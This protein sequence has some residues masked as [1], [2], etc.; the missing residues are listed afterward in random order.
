MLPNDVI[1][2]EQPGPELNAKTQQSLTASD[3]RKVI[4]W[5]FNG[6]NTDGS[7]TMAVSNLLL[8]PLKINLLA[9]D[10]G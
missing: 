4:Q 3:T 9:A 10:L 5:N 2:F 8:S 6:S 7:F 1:S